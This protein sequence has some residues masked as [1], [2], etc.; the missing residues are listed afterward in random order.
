MD[1]ALRLEPGGQEFHSRI[2]NAYRLAISSGLWR[3]FYALSND[4][5]YWAELVRILGQALF[6][7][8][9]SRPEVRLSCWKKRGLRESF[10]SL[11]YM[12]S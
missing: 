5:E 9:Q 10:F 6:A 11:F 3:N 2:K 1:Y 12:L 4:N 8:V 7:T